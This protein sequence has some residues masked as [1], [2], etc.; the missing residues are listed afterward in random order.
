MGNDREGA[1]AHGL[2]GGVMGHRGVLSRACVPGKAPDERVDEPG[3]QRPLPL[4]LF[5][6]RERCERR[7]GEADADM[8]IFPRVVG[9]HEQRGVGVRGH[10]DRRRQ[11][12]QGRRMNGGERFGREKRLLAKR[13]GL[14]KRRQTPAGG[15]FAL[16]RLHLGGD[17]QDLIVQQKQHRRWPV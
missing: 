16:Q 15:G 13:Y 14:I 4:E 8:A 17:V 5:E 6:P 12:H 2:G 9:P 11:A 3:C 1:P 10:R 7:R